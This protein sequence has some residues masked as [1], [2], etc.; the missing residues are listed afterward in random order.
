MFDVWFQYGDGTG[1]RIVDCYIDDGLI[2]SF[3]SEFHI[4]FDNEDTKITHW[5]PQPEPPK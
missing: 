5:M 1:E 3:S 4:K 2:S